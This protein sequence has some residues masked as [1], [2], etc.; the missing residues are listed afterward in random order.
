MEIQG[1]PEGF[2]EWFTLQFFHTYFRE[3]GIIAT[4]AG[5]IHS[6]NAYMLAHG[7]LTTAQGFVISGSSILN[8]I[9]IDSSVI[10]FNGCTATNRYA[11]NTQAG[12]AGTISNNRTRN[13]TN[14]FGLI[15]AGPTVSNNV[16]F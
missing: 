6:N 2:G 16:T 9:N 3:V 14:P 8:M 11:L 5:N 4:N 13:A 1:G 12:W 15:G 7:A 10:D